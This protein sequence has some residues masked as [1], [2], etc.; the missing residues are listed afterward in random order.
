MADAT[1]SAPVRTT[2]ALTEDFENGRWNYAVTIGGLKSGAKRYTYQVTMNGQRLAEGY[3]TTRKQR[4]QPTRFVCFGDNSYGGSSD[5]M[6][7]YPDVSGAPR[8]HHEHGRQ[9]L[10]ARSGRRVRALLL[11]GL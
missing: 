7:A 1:A 3:F 10:R 8:F 4:G 6:I 2:R 11:S 5:K 9:R